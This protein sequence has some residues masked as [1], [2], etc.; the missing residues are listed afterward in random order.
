MAAVNETGVGVIGT[1]DMAIDQLR[2]LEKQSG[3]F[4]TYLLMAHE[5]ANRE[6]TLRSYELITDTSCRCLRIPLN[7]FGAA[8]TGRS[9]PTAKH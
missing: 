9:F 1:P 3:G 4:G 8:G 7:R 6:S 5:S 2:R